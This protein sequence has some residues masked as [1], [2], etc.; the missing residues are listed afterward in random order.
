MWIIFSFCEMFSFVK[1][2]NY[3]LKKFSSSGVYKLTCLDCKKAY[4]GQIDE[5]FTKRYNE[6]KR[7]FS[8][9]SHS[10]NFAQH[11]NEHIKSS[12]AINNNMQILHHQK[13]DPHLNTIERFYIHT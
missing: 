2:D 1:V 7:S 4:I 9:N 5:Y 12:G 11:L 6:H 3:I 8:N 13:K 10:S